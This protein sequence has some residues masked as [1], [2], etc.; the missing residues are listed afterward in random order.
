MF[1]VN[2]GVTTAVVAPVNVTVW[3]AVPEPLLY[4]TTSPIVPV[5]KSVAAVPEQI[6][7]FCTDKVAVGNGFTVT[8]VACP[9]M[10]AKHAEV[11]EVAILVK[12]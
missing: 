1:E 7:A 8:V 4:V 5:N 2:T 11:P 3:S 12:V 10:F 6:V 9:V